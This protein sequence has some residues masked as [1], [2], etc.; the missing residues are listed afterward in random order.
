MFNPL[1]F[2]SGHYGGYGS[3]T[4]AKH[5]RINSGLFQTDTSLCTEMNL[6]LAL[7]HYDG[8]ASVAFTPVWGQGHTL[9]E[10]SGSA[11]ENLLAWIAECC[12]S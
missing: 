6:A 5:W 10:V 2:L 11:E 9:A 4:V 8:I 1:Y 7:N 3:A 12:K